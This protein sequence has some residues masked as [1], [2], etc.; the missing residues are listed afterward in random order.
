MA[1]GD[2]ADHE[3][4]QLLHWVNSLPVTSCLLVDSFD[5]LRSGDV[6]AD[7]FALVHDNEAGGHTLSGPPAQKVQ[8]VLTA[9]LQLVSV[10]EWSHRYVLR[11]PDTVLD[12]LDGSVLAIATLLRALK[13]RWDLLVQ[14]SQQRDRME[15]QLLRQVAKTFPTPRV[16]PPTPSVAPPT[17]TVAWNASTLHQAPKSRRRPPADAPCP[18]QPPCKHS[19]PSRMIDALDAPERSAAD[20]DVAAFVAADAQASLAMALAICKWIRSFGIPLRFEGL[21]AKMTTKEPSAFRT[22]AAR[23]FED[24]VILCQLT[25]VVVYQSGDLAAKAKLRPVTD[26]P[27]T[28]VPQGCCLRPQ[29]LAQQRHNLQLALALL[30]ELPTI[31]HPVVCAEELHDPRAPAFATH[32]WTLLQVLYRLMRRERRPPMASVT[33]KAPPPTP[34]TPPP[35]KASFPHVTAEQVQRVRTWVQQL[36]IEAATSDAAGILGDPYRNG[37][38]LCDVLNRVVAVERELKFHPQ[39][40]TLHQAKAN[41]Q[42][43]FHCLHARRVPLPP[44]YRALD[45]GYGL[46][47]GHFHAVWGFWWQLCQALQQVAAPPP[48][49]A[50]VADVAK[51]K[52]LAV[53]WLRAKGLLVHLD[54][55]AHP[56]FDEL[57]PY[58]VN[59]TLLLFVASELTLSFVKVRAVPDACPKSVALAHI[60]HALDLLRSVPCV[61]QRFLWS[62][63]KI[64]AGD[65]GVLLGL[66][67]DL[68]GLDYP[69][70]VP[71]APIEPYQP[72]DHLLPIREESD[73]GDDLGDLAERQRR[74]ECV[75]TQAAISSSR[76]WREI[77]ID[78]D[79]DL[80]P[81]PHAPLEVDDDEEARVPALPPP[82]APPCQ[83]RTTPPRQP[84]KSALPPVDTEPLMAWLEH[85]QIKPL[86]SLEGPRLLDFASG[87]VL[88]QI[89]EK[90]EHIRVLEGVCRQ[91]T[92]KKAPALHNI[93]KALDILRLKKTM[94]LGLL[95]KDREIYTG[96]RAVILTLLDQVRKVPRRFL[97]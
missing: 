26:Q 77:D 53:A 22:A 12:V 23:V 64:A 17:P 70:A 32:V 67:D 24:G 14:H 60:G 9:V 71:A 76:Q 46:L 96:D 8:V 72:L 82:Q 43:G 81:H 73:D 11:D 18:L 66:L 29:T 33:P 84:T 10:T 63:D 28:F 37:S 5:Q 34:E 39:P 49:E 92:N 16:A 58:F 86:P 44:L 83:R 36:G 80:L 35:P 94:P 79:D 3:D 31:T 6:L 55:A 50:S 69:L 85:L 19:I 20:A 56:T 40:R 62:D 78:A 45:N 87:L 97:R 75:H 95:R 59:G 51:R 21:L 2:D 1:S 52:I 90:V 7:I 27:G 89:V 54:P 47:R 13:K 30:R 57:K 15:A 91:P 74:M 68:Q 65:D 41:L 4:K 88:V 93:K 48:V 61:P 42:T 25:A 38:L